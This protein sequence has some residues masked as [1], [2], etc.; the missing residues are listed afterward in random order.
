MRKK[1]W[2]VTCEAVYVEM[3]YEEWRQPLYQYSLPIL[4]SL[5]TEAILQ[6]ALDELFAMPVMVVDVVLS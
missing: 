1:K 5:V 3:T 6:E 4:E 2:T